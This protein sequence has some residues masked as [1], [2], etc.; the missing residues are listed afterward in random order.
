[1]RV[2]QLAETQLL[3]DTGKLRYP[4]FQ[5]LL[6]GRLGGGGGARFDSRLRRQ[7]TEIFRGFINSS[8]QFTGWYLE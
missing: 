1:M 5:F 4:C 2:L 6:Q 8:R 3:A 7:L